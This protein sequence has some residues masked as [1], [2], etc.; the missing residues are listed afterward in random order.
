MKIKYWNI[1]ILVIAVLLFST[2]ATAAKLIPASE[3]GKD[4]AKADNSPI[5]EKVDEHLVLTPPG[6]QRVIFIHYKKGFAKPPWAGGGKKEPKCYDFLGKWVKWQELPVNYVIDP[7]NPDGLTEDF[8]TEAIYSGAEEWDSW[9]SSELFGT[10][11][12]D[13]NASWDSDAPDGR[14]ELL[15][16]NYPE[17]GVVAVT[18]VWGYF[19]GPPSSRE[20]IEFDILFDTDFT[21]GDATVASSTMDLQNIATHEIGHGAGLDDLYDTVCAE[22]TMYGYSDYGETKKRDLNTGDVTGIQELYGT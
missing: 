20:I 14:N 8:I 10:Y 22:E 19:S 18:V 9:T 3:K 11:S 15:F 16:G 4:K 1:S 5:I 21:W 2:T 6:L 7:D 13:Y 12:I 17:E